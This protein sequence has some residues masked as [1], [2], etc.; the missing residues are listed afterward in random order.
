MNTKVIYAVGAGI[1]IIGI[2]FYFLFNS[3]FLGQNSNNDD[4]LTS[5]VNTTE[6]DATEPISLP[7]QGTGN[8]QMT[9]QQLN[10]Q[11]LSIAINSVKIVPVNNESRLE[12]AFNAY[13]PNKGSAI[14]ETVT[15][16]VFVDGVRLSSGDL[17]S[18]TEGFVDSLESVYTII[19]NQTIVL[20]DREPL[21]EEGLKFFDS[22]GNWIGGSSNATQFDVNGTYFFTLNRGSETQAREN[23]FN[24]QYPITS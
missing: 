21:T 4:I 6:G 5:P 18:R 1:I 19:G 11:N 7:S 10:N 3:G 17:G 13:N 8:T 22:Q 12:V 9:P 16:N 20:R 2:V 23:S 15:Y 14:L 24:F